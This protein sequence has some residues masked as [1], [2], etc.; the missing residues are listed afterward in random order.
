[1][2]RARICLALAAAALLS[3]CDGAVDADQ[4]RICERAASAFHPDGTAIVRMRT[5]MADGADLRMFYTAREPGMAAALPAV[6]TCRFGDIRSEGRLELT[7]IRV[8]GRE[9]SD[10]ALFILKRWWLDAQAGPMA[11]LG[12]PPIRLGPALAYGVQQAVNALLPMA[13]YAALAVAFTLIHGLTGRIVLAMGELAVTGGAAMLAVT[14]A[15]QALGPLGIAHV[16]LGAGAAMAAAAAWAWVM[17]R[18]VLWR[19]R[20]RQGGGQGVLIASL[21]IAL[22]LREALTLQQREGGGW[23]PPLF[24]GALPV[25]GGSDYIA[26]VTPAILL[27]TLATGGAVAATLLVMRHGAFGRAWRAM[28]DDPRMA[29]LCGLSPARVLAQTA[30]LSGALAGLAG[31]MLVL[32]FGSV[33]ASFGLS[34]TL[35]SLAAAILG[36][37]G[38][39]PGAAL[40]GVAIGLLETMWSS[41]F[42]IA[43]RDVVMYALLIVALVARPDGLAGPTRRDV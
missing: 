1:M 8:G 16:A 32:V 23:L 29:A 27:A 26:T 39:V 36:G 38:S 21:G 9:L 2:T 19:F 42:D 28:A 18:F 22:V 24:H 30:V 25:A 3:G 31:A 34:L 37:I 10:S 11:A 41:A 33:G 12:R 14:A 43:Y 4:A 40:G 13:L 20:D 5:T 35:K 6:I 7:G 15:G 17:G